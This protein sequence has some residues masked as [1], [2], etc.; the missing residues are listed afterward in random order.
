MRSS[1]AGDAF[2]LL[3][4]VR[5]PRAI[6]GAG[7]FV[8]RAVRAARPV[9]GSQTED[10]FIVVD[11]RGRQIGA[12][13]FAAIHERARD[14]PLPVNHPTAWRHHAT[15]CVGTTDPTRGEDFTACVRPLVGSAAEAAS[16]AGM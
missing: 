10:C 15:L 1:C 12:V 14:D 8:E 11:V 6:L 16:L 3:G 7:P 4:Q 5:L 9:R 13:G 2:Q